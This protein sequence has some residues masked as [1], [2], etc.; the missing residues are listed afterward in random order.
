MIAAS[1]RETGVGHISIW[2]WV[3]AIWAAAMFFVAIISCFSVESIYRRTNIVS[4]AIIV[5]SCAY[6]C[7]FTIEKDNKWNDDGYVFTCSLVAFGAFWV[8]IY[9]ALFTARL[10]PIFFIVILP[11][12]ACFYGSCVFFGLKPVQETVRAIFR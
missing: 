11:I 5:L 4:T 9:A 3:W 10:N 7:F 8:A 6:M 12:I 1:F 2:F